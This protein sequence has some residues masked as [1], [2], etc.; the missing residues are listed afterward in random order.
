MLFPLVRKREKDAA[1]FRDKVCL[2]AIHLFAERGLSGVTMR[3]LAQAMGTS[4]MKTYHYFRDKDEILA[5]VLT[6]TFDRFADALDLAGSVEGSAYE[7]AKAM[8]VAFARFALSE[9]ES[10]RLM[11]EIPHPQELAYPNMSAAM[12]RTRASMRRI[13]EEL[14]AAGLVQGDPEFLGHVFWSAIHGPI[15]LYL[16]GKTAPELDVNDIIDVQILGLFAF[17]SPQNPYLPE[18]AAKYPLKP[19]GGTPADAKPEGQ[20]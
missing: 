8:R 3:A 5:E 10:Y 7:R 17:L 18:Y 15:S 19:A 12:G 6:R 11:F 9:P 1:A 16:A 20:N 14:L 13:M 2:A 4:T